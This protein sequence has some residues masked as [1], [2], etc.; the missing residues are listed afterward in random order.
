MTLPPDGATYREVIDNWWPIHKER[1]EKLHQPVGDKYTVIGFHETIEL[2]RKEYQ[3][4][5]KQQEAEK[6][7]IEQEIS[8][9][10]DD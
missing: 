3:E 4:Q 7:I 6:D 9:A 8:N 1:M 2:A 10:P 5:L